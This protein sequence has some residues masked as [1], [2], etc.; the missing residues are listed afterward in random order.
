M[1]AGLKSFEARFRKDHQHP[2]NRWL[3]FVGQPLVAV[4]LLLLF[5]YWQWGLL[6]I[7][8]GYALMFTG[9]FLFEGNLPG[10]LQNPGYVLIASLAAIETLGRGLSSLRLPKFAKTDLRTRARHQF[11]TWKRFYG[12]PLAQ[13]CFFLPTYVFLCERLPRRHGLSVLEV[14]CGDGHLLA[15]LPKYL[16]SVQLFGID[17]TAGMLQQARECVGPETNLIQADGQQLPFAPGCF[18]LVVCAHAFHH[19]PDQSQALREM[20]RVLRPGGVACVLDGDRDDA[21]GWLLFDVFIRCCEGPV[22]HA[23][24]REMRRLLAGAGFA[25]IQQDWQDSFPPVLLTSGLAKK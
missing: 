3:H 16:P 10:V 9:H 25:H 24:A 7:L 23:S 8:A 6:C 1:F 12:G 19:F 5:F 11:E 17:L 13:R 14:G 21:F 15:M 22:H 18:D 4:G 20:R 2:V